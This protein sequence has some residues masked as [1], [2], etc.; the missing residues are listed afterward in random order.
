MIVVAAILIGVLPPPLSRFAGL[1]P[2]GQG[3][4]TLSPEVLVENVAYGVT[5]T[6]PEI[7]KSSELTELIIR[8]T[9]DGQP[10]DLL[11]NDKFL[12]AT[13][14]SSDLKDL[15]VFNLQENFLEPEPGVLVTQHPFLDQPYTM[16][17]EINDVTSR[18][19]HGVDK[20]DY[21]ARLNL[22]TDKKAVTEAS[23]ITKERE[24]DAEHTIQL[25]HDK[26][27]AGQPARLSVSVLDAGGNTV[28]LL[29]DFD[30]FYVIV[31]QQKEFYEMW[32]VDQA[33]SDAA[34]VTTQETVFPEAGRYIFGIRIFADD[35]SGVDFDQVFTT[36]FIVE[37]E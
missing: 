23:L 17:V 6:T 10:I 36:S 35:G 18:D 9:K 16:W 12:H 22:N 26:L 28:P 8:V 21:I 1:L 3:E 5:I 14:V 24:F 7:I 27:V 31:S 34:Q 37:S 29:D 13:L 32:H 4:K 19:H 2:L 30:H 11:A 20:T 33:L 15:A 25:N